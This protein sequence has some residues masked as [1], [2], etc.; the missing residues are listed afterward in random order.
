MHLT[1]SP[2]PSPIGP[3]AIACDEAGRVRGVGFGEESGA[4]PVADCWA[5]TEAQ[6]KAIGEPT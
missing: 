5:M 6:V 2:L 3:L 4:A 1:L